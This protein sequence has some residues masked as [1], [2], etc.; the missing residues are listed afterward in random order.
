MGGISYIILSYPSQLSIYLI[1]ASAIQKTKSMNLWMLLGG[2]KRPKNSSF[3]FT[4]LKNMSTDSL[5]L[6][7]AD[8]RTLNLGTIQTESSTPLWYPRQSQLLRCRKRSF[9]QRFCQFS[10]Q[11]FPPFCRGHR[12]YL[13]QKVNRCLKFS[14][15]IWFKSWRTWGRIWLS[16]WIG[17]WILWMS[18]T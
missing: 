18:Y 14:N 1:R 8:L 15:P 13:I 2:N 6:L 4:Y 12:T 17:L 5:N 9:L 3:F 11:W 7:N 16:I 10:K